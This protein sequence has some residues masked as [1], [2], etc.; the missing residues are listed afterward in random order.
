MLE[1][2]NINP[3]LIYLFKKYIQSK[4][5]TNSLPKAAYDKVITGNIIGKVN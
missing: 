4:Q 3:L 5:R 1:K 2:K